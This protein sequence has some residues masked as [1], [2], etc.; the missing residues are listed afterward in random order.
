MIV[1]STIISAQYKIGNRAIKRGIWKNKQ[2][3]YVEGQVIVKLK[4]EFSI[5][6][7]N[8][9]FIQ[10]PGAKV[11]Q[12]SDSGKWL[13][14]EYPEGVDVL[15][16]VKE[17]KLNRAI[18]I[19][20]LNFVGHVHWEPNDTYYS[21]GLQWSL[22]NTAQTPPGGTNDADIDLPEAWDITK[23]INSTMIAVLDTGI[24]IDS[25]TLALS[26][27]DLQNTSR[28]IKGADCIDLPGSD[29]YLVGVRDASGH[30]TH[31][32]GIIAA[33]TNNSIG[34]SGIANGCSLLA[35]QIMNNIGVGGVVHLK[36]GIEYAVN[37]GAKIINIS[38]GWSADSET[39]VQAL[40]YA[41]AH[42]V[43][44][45][46]SA[47]NDSSGNVTFPARY[48]PNYSNIL[49]VSATDHNDVV[50]S[51]SN[52][53]SEV[54]V[55][56]PGGYGGSRGG[57]DIYSTTPNYAGFYYH[58]SS[59]YNPPVPLNY[60]Y[61]YGTSMAAPHVSAI[62]GLILSINPNLYPY[63]IKDIIQQ[64]AEDKGTTGRDNSYGYGRVN[65]YKALKYTIENYGGTFNQNVTIPA[66]D[67]W[68]LQPGVT[69][70]FASGCA[71]IV[72][73]TLNASGTSSSG[74]T[75]TKSGANN[76]SGIQF[77]SGSSGNLQYCT[78]QY[79]THGVYCY[80]SS[81]TISY[82]HIQNNQY[83]G[84][85]CNYYS[86]PALDHN[87]IQNNYTGISCNDH[88][89]PNMLSIGS[90]PG[91][92]VIRNNGS[93]GISANYY[94]NPV[95]GSSSSYGG[96][97]SI[98]N[99]GSGTSA[100]SATDYCTINA[101]KDWWNV[102]SSPYF[103][104]SH[105]YKV[106][107]T[108]NADPG[109]STDP[110]AGRTKVV[111]DDSR[112]ISGEVN[113]S[114]QG[115]GDNL[116]DAEAKQ[117]DKKY[118]E[119]IPLFLN[120]FKSDKDALLGKYALC[121]I[122]ECFTQAV[123][124][125]YLDFSKRE[126]KPLLK[127]GSETYVAALELETHQMVNLELY[128]E[129]VNNLETILKKYNLN[130]EIEKNTLFTLGAFHNIFFG[131]K[132]N[133]DK[134]F[135]E[136]KQK[137]PNDDLVNQIE[138]V[139]GLGLAANSSVRSGDASTPLIETTQ[140]VKA[141]V[142]EDAITNYPNPFNPT[143]KIS[144]A[145]KESAKVSLKVY[146]ILGK[147]VANLADGYYEAGKYVATFDGSKLTSGIYFYRLTT[148]TATIAKKMMLVK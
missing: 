122:E 89:S 86:S 136:L 143:T 140:A 103:S 42:D 99:N 27:P 108:V 15:D 4:S 26:H 6:A 8:P 20:E 53:G 49:S 88:S 104:E 34:I 19:A 87:T 133:S 119:A 125:D 130:G 28:I 29:A 123:K 129:A 70:A 116:S 30:G 24:P 31:V 141:T 54:C 137:Y 35:V 22:K 11:I 5:D 139:R 16:S 107:S 91:Q 50:A 46:I 98:Y 55:S 78:I 114:I 117:K 82:S 57:N 47:G 56:A 93:W 33:E 131:D 126:I 95:V 134:Y 145:L 94:S 135:E 69:L 128:K 106:N 109:L 105:F 96:G 102:I 147:E 3:D 115:S 32:A 62:A 112:V 68:N 40:D 37:N 75:F 61:L 45:V 127:E 65:A 44:L 72:N 148:P 74:I 121:K 60:G 66:G 13:L 2:V 146:D 25:I 120:V 111:S 101:Q 79:G 52:T 17:L 97:N 10:Q 73:G 142:S 41:E 138:I 100:I 64:T 85:Y 48:S 110:N 77:N 81:P 113:F 59:I 76:W 43:L 80:N 90:Y 118:D 23:G 36:A 39:M 84:V 1:V 58:T 38:A 14:L 7:F 92:N 67:T 71:L 51:Y 132:T 21:S 124:K 18:E 9:T 144:F 12:I 83:D 63:Q